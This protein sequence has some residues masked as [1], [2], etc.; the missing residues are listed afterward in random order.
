MSTTARIQIPVLNMQHYTQG[1]ANQKAEFVRT[2]G[3]GLRELGFVAIENHQVDPA[4][5]RQTYQ[6][7][8]SFFQLPKEAKERYA[9]VGGQRG[10][11]GFMKEHAKDNAVGDLKEFW[12]VGR[13]LQPGHPMQGQYPDNVWPDELPALRSVTLTLF[14]QL[15]ANARI[16]LRALGDY[17]ELADRDYFVGAIENGNHI[18]RAIHY[19]PLQPGMPPNAVRAA[20]HEDI[21]MITILCESTA[22]GLEILTRDNEWVAIDALAGQLVVDAGDMLS[23]L[24][25]GVIPATTHRV[26]N[27][28][29]ENTVRYS[30]PYFVHPY[31]EFNIECLPCCD[32]ADNPSRF[33]AI[34]AGAFLNQRLRE[35]GLLK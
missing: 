28:A 27:P 10:F 4:L 29:G 8:E 7:F 16:L 9:G 18:L 19:P 3:E 25:N 22:A 23:R 26:V 20:A 6:L 11:T 30:L 2:W 21:N 34:T 5:I 33:P 17:F 32:T 31:S 35:I 13:E 15:E 24:T 12:H 14:E 1:D